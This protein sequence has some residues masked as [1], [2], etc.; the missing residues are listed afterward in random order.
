MNKTNDTGL[1][2]DMFPS[3]VSGESFSF[4]VLFL[5]IQKQS[6]REWSDQAKCLT[7]VSEWELELTM[8]L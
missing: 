6:H 5:H 2:Q 4:V 3:S 7:S 8:S 1:T